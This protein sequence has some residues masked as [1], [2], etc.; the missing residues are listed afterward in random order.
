[1][2]LAIGFRVRSVRGTQFRRWVTAALGEYLVK[3]FVMADARLKER[4]AIAI[5]MNCSRV[6]PVDAW[7]P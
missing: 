1:M 7:I 5:S 3:G 4:G 2:I 6:Y